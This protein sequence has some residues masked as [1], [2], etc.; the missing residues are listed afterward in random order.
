MLDSSDVVLCIIDYQEKLLPKIAG[1]EAILARGIRLIRFAREMDIP[2]LLSEQYPKGLGRTVESVREA[3]GHVTLIEKLSFGCLGSAQ[4][5]E[6]LEATNRKQ[7]LL[8]GVETHV[9][10]L[11]T[12]LAALES[13]YQVYLAADAS[14][15]RH[16]YDHDIA[17]RRLEREGATL[18]TAETAMFEMLREAGTPQFKRVLQIVK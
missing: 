18:V 4:Y 12:A 9:C 8:A 15:A 16:V 11:Q 13:Q 3:M 2:I 17:L 5:R 10:V 14:G 6:A 1:A 7:V